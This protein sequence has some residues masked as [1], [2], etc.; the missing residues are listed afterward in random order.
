MCDQAKVVACPDVEPEE[1]GAYAL[2]AAMDR[3]REQVDALAVDYDSEGLEVLTALGEVLHWAFALDDHHKYRLGCT[4]YWRIRGDDADG[5]VVAALM[6]ARNR[7]THG[8]A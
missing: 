2:T 7:I 8:L 3:L 6:Y 4:E 1:L 5:K